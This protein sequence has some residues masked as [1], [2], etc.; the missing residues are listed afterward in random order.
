MSEDKV[1]FVWYIPGFAPGGAI[2]GQHDAE[3]HDV[4]HSL[5]EVHVMPSRC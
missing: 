2:C 3:P 4:R 1:E 5:D